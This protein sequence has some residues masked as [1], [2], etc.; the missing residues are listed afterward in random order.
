MST[1]LCAD[2]DCNFMVMLTPSG[3]AHVD[4]HGLPTDH[5]A[6]PS[7]LPRPEDDPMPAELPAQVIANLSSETGEEQH[8]IDAYFDGAGA[9]VSHDWKGDPDAMLEAAAARVRREA[10]TRLAAISTVR[11]GEPLTPDAP[12]TYTRER[13]DLSLASADYWQG[14]SDA[15]D[16]IARLLGWTVEEAPG[17]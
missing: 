2:S 8:V 4:T 11:T 6:W 10:E 12:F 3:W 14:W 17:D 9:E 5:Q 1:H 16:H 15:E 7:H 13:P